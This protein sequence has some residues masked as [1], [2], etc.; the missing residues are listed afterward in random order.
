M[1]F[2]KDDIY[3]VIGAV[4]AFV[5]LRIVTKQQQKNGKK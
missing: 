3:L 4:L 2:K 5:V 1:L